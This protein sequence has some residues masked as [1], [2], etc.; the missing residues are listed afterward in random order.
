MANNPG[1]LSMTDNDNSVDISVI[2]PVFQD[3]DGLLDTVES[4][5]AQDFPRD[6]YEIVIADNNSQDGTKQAAIELQNT[7]PDLIRVIHQDRIQNSYATRNAGVRA[8]KGQIC[9]FID[10]DMKADVDYLANVSRYFEQNKELMYLGCNIAI[11][12]NGNT[13]SANMNRKYGFRIKNYFEKNNFVVTACLSVRRKIFEQVGY[14][15]SRLESGGDKEFG[16]RVHAAGLG[17][18]YDHD[19]V[20]YHPSR[21]TYVSMLKKYKRI[22][23]GHAQLVHYYPERYSYYKSNRYYKTSRYIPPVFRKS[24]AI[25]SAVIF[26][27]GKYFYYLPI[28]LCALFE[29]RKELRK[30]ARKK[31]ED[32]KGVM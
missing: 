31:D 9:C 21:T 20:L 5:I 17:Q 24:L 32:E 27:L 11:L 30:L 2:I 29:F 26:S 28:N 10:A 1:D 14:F 18:Y 8:A 12:G 23:R 7:Y 6:Q 22:A 3:R 4:L 19:L 15:D 13:I 25:L 16:Q